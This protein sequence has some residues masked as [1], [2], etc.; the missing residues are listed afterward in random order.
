MNIERAETK[1]VEIFTTVKLVEN[2]LIKANYTYLESKDLSANSPDKGLPL[3]RRPK[4]KA[5]L[6]YY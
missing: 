6:I 5:G 3:L 1:G 2:A 4:H